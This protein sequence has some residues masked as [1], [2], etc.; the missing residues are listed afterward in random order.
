LLKPAYIVTCGKAGIRGVKY[1]RGVGQVTKCGYENRLSAQSSYA[2]A[3]EHLTSRPH[4]RPL[5][6]INFTGYC[7]IERF[8]LSIEVDN[9]IGVN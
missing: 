4:E 3:L 6:F 8:G 9:A 5:G 2:A 1:P 7:D